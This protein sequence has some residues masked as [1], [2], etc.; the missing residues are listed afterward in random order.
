MPLY[1]ASDPGLDAARQRVIQI[2]RDDYNIRAT[3]PA[4][5]RKA[6]GVPADPYSADIYYG[7]WLINIGLYPDGQE[8]KYIYPLNY[9]DPYAKPSYLGPNDKP[10]HVCRPRGT[11]KLL[12]V[13]VD[14][15]NLNVTQSESFDALAQAITQINGKYAE[16]ARAVGLDTPILKLEAQAAFIS[17]PPAPMQH[18]LLSPDLVQKYTG[19]DPSQFDILTQVDLDANNTYATTEN[20]GSFGFAT[21]GCGDLPLD[22]NMWIGLTAKDQLFEGS[23]ARLRSTL[24]HELLHT[25]GYPIGI[26]GLHEWV[27]GDGTLPDPSDQCDQNSLPTLML[28]WTDTDGDGIVEILD[29]TP[30]G[31]EQP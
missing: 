3:A 7:N 2:L 26:T 11:I 14:Y 31:I 16:A 1:P 24:G 19:Y 15:Q 17:P 27:C 8:V 4:I 5:G 12:V 21:S 29:P 6:R 10:I 20:F 13:F 30:Y 18:H 9:S 22:V 23:D 28:G 25:M